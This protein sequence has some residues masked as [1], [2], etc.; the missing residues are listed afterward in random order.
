MRSK[1]MI[2]SGVIGVIALALIIVHFHRGEIQE[3][4][5]EKE[6]LFYC[7]AGLRPPV[8]EIV[9]IFSREHNAKIDCTYAGAATLR[10]Q[11]Q[12]TKRGDFF[13]PGDV[14]WIDLVETAGLVASEHTVCY[15]TPVILV[16]KGNPKNIKS[17]DDLV[18][19]GIRLGFGD[20]EVIPIG[21]I[22]IRIFEKN[23]I[24][25][26]EVK[27]NLVF[28]SLTVNELGVQIKVGKVDAVIVWDATA[29]YFADS[30]DI[31]RIPKEKNIISTVA[32]ALLRSSK[33]KE[34]ARE[35]MNFVTSKRGQE[36]FRTHHFS[37]E[38]PE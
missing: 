4:Q 10:T 36:I 32:I 23:N 29:A 7:G 35:F 20:P 30:G 12:V 24:K 22:A 18:K 8:S 17:L 16:R 14:S 34:L 37:T 13:M 1:I 19:Q 11:M 31:V 26:E 3:K 38:L 5:T 15:F 6:L 25:M 21:K 9:R 2:A 33:H 28:N 27:K